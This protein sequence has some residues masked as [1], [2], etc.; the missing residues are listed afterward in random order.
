MKFWK[1]LKYWQKGATIGFLIPA[2]FA[3]FAFLGSFIDGIEILGA[4]SV[5]FRIPTFLLFWD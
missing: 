3:V 5:I 1:K 2:V 4:P